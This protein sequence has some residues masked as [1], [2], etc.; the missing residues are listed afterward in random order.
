MKNVIRFTELMDVLFHGSLTLKRRVLAYLASILLVT[1]GL[2]FVM[3]FFPGFWGRGKIGVRNMLN[4]RL[5]T[6]HESI[7][8]RI[9]LMEG[10]T[11]N[12]S[13]QLQ[14]TIDYNLGLKTGV[15]ELNGDGDA[16]LELENEMYGDLNAFLLVS[17]SS[18][19]FAVL[20]TTAG[21]GGVQDNYEKAGLYLRRA[22]ATERAII[23]KINLYRGNAEVAR[24]RG[25]ELNTNW[26]MEFGLEKFEEYNR[27]I[28]STKDL[29]DSIYWSERKDIADSWESAML[30][31]IPVVNSKGD[32]YGVCGFEFSDAYFAGQY[33]SFESNMGTVITVLAPVSEGKLLAGKGLVG[34]TE[35]VWFDK[36]GD[37]DI[38]EGRL[39]TYSGKNDTYIGLQKETGI[40]ST[41][42]NKWVVALLIPKSQCMRYVTNTRIQLFIVVILFVVLMILACGYLTHRFITPI[43]NSIRALRNNEEPDGD[44]ASVK[45]LDELR[46]FIAAEKK[47][48]QIDALPSNIEEMLIAFEKK[49]ETLTPTEKTLLSYYAEG[50]SME[51]CAREMFISELTVKKHNTNLNKKLEV[52]S[53]SQLM[54]YIELFERADRLDK[55]LG[56]DHTEE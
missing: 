13:R 46:A 32:D 41:D 33:P 14:K 50:F 17:G 53:R 37:L 47:K 18:G 12:L 6:V 56:K 20:D 25:I 39:F 5:E 44:F 26:D 1:L 51:E 21:N 35:G 2:I 23:P 31:G 28:E 10:Y 27:L 4:A 24:Q 42:G 29:P 55:L 11:L 9:E 54:V 49:V 22:N 45:E 3:F 43:T 8:E 15:T 48:S 52:T 19:I 36:E 34:N 38:N 30:L 16:I 7:S 40:R